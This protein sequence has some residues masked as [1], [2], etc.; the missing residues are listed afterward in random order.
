MYKT[1]KQVIEETGFRREYIY[2]LTRKR[3]FEKKYVMNDKGTMVPMLKKLKEPL[4]RN[5]PPE[6]E[7]YISQVEAKKQG[8]NIENK[9]RVKIGRYIYFKIN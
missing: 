8:L 9:E 7:G 4:G 1:I 5:V 3:Y 6:I 2:R